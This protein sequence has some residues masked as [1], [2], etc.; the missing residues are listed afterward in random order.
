MSPKFKRKF[1]KWADD[2][3]I[4]M[5]IH[6][7]SYLNIFWFSYIFKCYLLMNNAANLFHLEYSFATFSFVYKLEIKKKQSCFANDLNLLT[8]FDI[9]LGFVVLID[10]RIPKNN[11]CFQRI[12]W[13][14]K[15]TIERKTSKICIF[16]VQGRLLSFFWAMSLVFPIFRGSLFR[17]LTFDECKN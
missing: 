15:S 17:S 16:W 8:F 9:N 5:L 2:F 3:Q 10:F 11:K 4:S 6:V 7:F 14:L 1:S 13:I 12:L